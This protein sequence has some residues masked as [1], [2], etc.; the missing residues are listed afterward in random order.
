M[1]GWIACTYTE[2]LPALDAVDK[3]RMAVLVAKGVA[4]IHAVGLA[5]TLGEEPAIVKNDPF[6]DIIPSHIEKPALIHNVHRI[7]LTWSRMSLISVW[8]GC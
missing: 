1:F 5:N 8:V 3:L 7:S 4:E 6:T 2:L